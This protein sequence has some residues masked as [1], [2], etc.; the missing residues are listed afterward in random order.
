MKKYIALTENGYPLLIEG[1]IGKGH[2]LLFLGTIDH[3]W[4]NFPTQAVYL[5][6][7]QQ[8]VTYLGG[9]ATQSQQRYSGFVGD[10]V[11]VELPEVAEELTLK[12][13]SGNI[14]FRKDKG[15]L[16]FV[17][18]V[19]GAYELQSSGGIVW[20]RIAINNK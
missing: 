11:V 12:G 20:V 10:T 4:G 5:P 13:P 14:G 6:L 17:P 9:E 2:V 1:Q 18:E 16:H 19:A 3:G 8:M 15:K 7:V